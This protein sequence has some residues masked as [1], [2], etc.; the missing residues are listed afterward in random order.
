MQQF[1]YHSFRFNLF[2]SICFRCIVIC[3]GKRNFR[4]VSFLRAIF[5]LPGVRDIV[6]GTRKMVRFKLIF[7]CRNCYKYICVCVTESF[8]ISCSKIKSRHVFTICKTFLDKPFSSCIFVRIS[9]STLFFAFA[10]SRPFSQFIHAVALSCT[11]TRERALC[12]SFR[13]F[14]I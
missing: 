5:L 1:I 11:L 7:F 14:S 6:I 2:H 10:L 13:C 3:F 4:V 8:C 12:V 9:N